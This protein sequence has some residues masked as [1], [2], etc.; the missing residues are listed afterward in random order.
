MCF[1]ATASFVAGGALGAAGVVTIT[2]TKKDRK[3]L[4]LASIPLLFGIQQAIEGV[5]WL[6]FST[7]L[8]NAV[9]TY[10]YTVVA[11][12][13]WPIY[14]PLA[15]LAVETDL[16]RKKVLYGLSAIGFVLGVYLLDFIYIAPVVSHI[17]NCSI[18]YGFGNRFPRALLGVY[19]LVTCG[20][21]F[22]SS[23]RILRIFGAALLASFFVAGWFYTQT[24]F[25]VWCFFAAIL[26]IIIFWFVTTGTASRR[27]KKKKPVSK[28]TR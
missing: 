22:V 8:L 5:V 9:A 2:R 15:V 27:G 21:F 23:H 11:N 13:V 18:A 4:P 19:V 6:S 10:A 17:V 7:P 20:S 3:L 14:T 24:F 1:S 12:V 16:Q 25:S 26:S 28:K